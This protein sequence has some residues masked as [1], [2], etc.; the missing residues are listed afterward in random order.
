MVTKRLGAKCCPKCKQTDSTDFSKCRH[1]GTRYDARLTAS[2]RQQS[3]LTADLPY[4]APTRRLLGHVL[5]GIVGTV[6]VGIVWIVTLVMGA[7]SAVSH[8]KH[9]D[10]SKAAAVTQS[11]EH[12]SFS[13]RSKSQPASAGHESA[14]AHPRAHSHAQDVKPI[15]T[16][17][18]AKSG[19]GGDHAIE[20]KSVHAHP[21]ISA[22]TED[23]C[24]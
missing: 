24:A 10:A 12:K 11:T 2:G 22:A 14:T 16:H 18:A 5:D 19:H 15:H 6:I 17:D 23:A 7:Q 4:A 21:A 1:C 13:D 20:S 8:S 9:A 3:W